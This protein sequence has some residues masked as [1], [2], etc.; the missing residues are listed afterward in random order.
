MKADI[1][2]VAELIQVKVR[3]SIGEGNVMLF[4]LCDLHRFVWKIEKFLGEQ[5]IRTARERVA[6][7]RKESKNDRR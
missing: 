1:K 3:D 6:Q 7:R 5:P 4:K 2:I